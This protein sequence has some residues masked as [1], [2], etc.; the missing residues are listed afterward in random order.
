MTTTLETWSGSCHC[1]FPR[2]T[3]LDDHLEL[4]LAYV[5]LTSLATLLI[6]LHFHIP[7]KSYERFLSVES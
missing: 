6:Q 7:L 4:G 5:K 3:I 1:M 2:E